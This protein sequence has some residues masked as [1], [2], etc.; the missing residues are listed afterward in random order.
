MAGRSSH[1]AA[2]LLLAVITGLIVYVS[3][4]PFR[5]ELDGPS[6]REALHALSW[7]RAGRGDMLNNLLLYV[8]FVFCVALVIE[9]RS[10][11]TAGGSAEQADN[12]RTNNHGL[13][14]NSIT[15]EDDPNQKDVSSITTGG[16]SNG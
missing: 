4:Y 6:L 10:G 7:Q 5:F 14:R 16:G 12:N 9:P 8:P 3:L 11:R 13:A 2:P 15:G 1:F